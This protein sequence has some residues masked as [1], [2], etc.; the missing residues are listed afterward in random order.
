MDARYPD[1]F[2]QVLYLKRQAHLFPPAK[3]RR[4][5][6]NNRSSI[7]AGEAANSSIPKLFEAYKYMGC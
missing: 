2:W 7:I 1:N 5:Q 3:L 4:G 6:T